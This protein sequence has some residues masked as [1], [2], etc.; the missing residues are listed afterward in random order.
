MFW[1]PPPVPVADQTG[2]RPIDNLG[3][4]LREAS[5]IS[6]SNSGSADLTARDAADQRRVVRACGGHARACAPGIHPSTA[7]TPPIMFRSDAW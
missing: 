5:P 1:T 6:W 7:G 4:V 2:A 3:M